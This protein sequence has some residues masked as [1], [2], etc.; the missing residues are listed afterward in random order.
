MVDGAKGIAEVDV[1]Y[2]HVLVRVFDDFYECLR[3]AMS[4]WSWRS[5]FVCGQKHSSL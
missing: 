3:A 1:G 2:V 5:V 4:V